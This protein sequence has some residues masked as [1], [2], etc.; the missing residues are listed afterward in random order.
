MSYFVVVLYKNYIYIITS[1]ATGGAS[2]KNK[3]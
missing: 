3:Y 1:Q 2:Q